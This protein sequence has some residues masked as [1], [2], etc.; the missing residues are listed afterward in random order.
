MEIFNLHTK[1]MDDYKSYIKSFVNIQDEDIHNKVMDNFKSDKLFPDPL[2]QFNPSF[3]QEGSIEELIENAILESEIKDVFK[4]FKLYKHQVDAIKLGSEGKD[5]IVTSGT[6][7]GK[8]LTYIGTIFNYLLKNK[9]KLGT[10]IQAII[11]YPMNALINSQT[12]ELEKYRK[13]YEDETG[14]DFP[15]KFG[16]YTGQESQELRD[17]M[18]NDMPDIVLTN[19]MMLE[20][21]LSRASDNQIKESLYKNLQ[22]LVFDELHTYRGRQGSDVAMLIRRI[23]SKCENDVSCMGTSATMVAGENSINAQKLEVANVAKLIFGK[24]FKIDQIIN[25]TLSTSFSDNRNIP[26]KD[27]LQNCINCGID[28]RDNEFALISNKVALWLELEIALAEKED[29]LIRRKPM[30]FKEIVAK[31]AKY[32][33]CDE[34]KCS[35]Y[36]KAL[37]KWISKLNEESKGKTYLPFKFHQFISQTGS[38]Y[39]SL[40]EQGER[41]ISLDYVKEI[42]KKPLY[43][44][45][46]SR[47]TGATFVCVTLDFETNKLKHREF[48]TASTTEDDEP[49]ADGYLILDENAWN[50]NEDIEN[51]PD[52][53]LKRNNKG[54]IQGV[55]KK[56]KER[57]P[58]KIYYNAYGEFSDSPDEQFSFTCWFMPE[59]L[60]FD[61][62]SGTFYDTKTNEG[63]KLTKLGSEGR[64][65][66]TTISTFSILNQMSSSFKPQEQKLL[67]FTDN[68]QDAALQSGH[69]NDFISVIRLRAAIYKAIANAADY[70]D[71]TT[72]GQ[73]IFDALELP[74]LEYASTDTEPRFENRRRE[75]QETFKTYLMYRA[76]YDLRRSWRV[77]LPNLE[78]CALLEIDYKYL[79]EVAS[80]TKAWSDIIIVN[81]METQERRF[82]ILNI[83]EYFRLHYSIH[84]ENYLTSIKIQ[85]NKKK[86]LENLRDP[87]KLENNEDIKEPGFMRFKTIK[88]RNKFTES[89]GRQSRLGKYIVAEGKKIDLVDEL[90]GENY[91]S[92]I[93]TMMDRLDECGYLKQ[94]VV[95][96]KDGS[97]TKMYM[98]KIDNILWKCGDRKTVRKDSVSDRSYKERELKPNE[99]FQKIYQIDF[100]T[101]KQFRAA[102]H[103]GQLTNDDRKEREKNF[104]VDLENFQNNEGQFDLEK[105]NRESISALYC[106]P[107]MELGIDISNL[108]IVHMRNVPPNPANYAQRSGRAGRSG[109][110]ALVFTYCSSYSSHD[111]HYFNN[112]RDMVAGIVAPPKIDL[113]NEE[114]LRTHL[115]ALVLSEIGLH[116]L[117]NSIESLIDTERFPLLNLSEE[118]K[119]KIKLSDNQK[120][121][122]ELPNAASGGVSITL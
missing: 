21:L 24:K 32:S 92:F 12:E 108:S 99:F 117:T 26:T 83:L 34:D 37:L 1:I 48:R 43:Q 62:T 30:S 35:E 115:N 2:I 15:I 57:I 106:S 47:T 79:D 82:F 105:I 100:S 113:L 51:L 119:E 73:G 66:S 23:K 93:E 53:Y 75:Y 122:N 52:S 13:Q 44:V 4:G 46:F 87:W 61:P 18:K 78:Q 60:L 70:L 91:N 67:S 38:V 33:E 107:T 49:T 76:L 111:K 50:P 88:A 41:I 97:E 36:L 22:F 110:A 96:A 69:F 16:Q 104:R 59:K 55:V 11:V 31:F 98:L 95:E 116:E 118:I 64:S 65:T 9:T 40:C 3:K 74:F 10:G 8:S 109:Q 58:Q 90:K 68:R 103:T 121:K 112:S 39:I 120:Q 80:D 89:I 114:L 71:Y 14:K 54:E 86:I 72:L 56:Y 7:S 6:G 27:E 77:I 45:V 42:N 81:Q 101:I 20:L 102:D 84:S 63:T 25:E 17:K 29:V 85:E 94:E 28:S 19:Y 5:F